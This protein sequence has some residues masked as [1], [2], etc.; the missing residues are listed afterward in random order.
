MG[1]LT[2]SATGAPLTGGVSSDIWRVDLPSGPVC[3]KR[4]LAKTAGRGGLAGAGRAQSLRGALDALGR[5]RGARRRAGAARPGRG[6]RR[7]G[8]GV[9]R[10]GASSAVEG[11]AARRPCR[12]GFRGGGRDGAG[13]HPRRHR[14]RSGGR[15]A[16]PD[17]RHLPRNPTGAL[18][19]GHRPRPPR[20]RGGAARSR[21]DH[22]AHQARAGAWRREPEEHPRRPARPGV[23]RRRVRLVGRSGLRPRLL[24][25]SFASQMPL[26]AARL[27]AFSRL[28]RPARAHLPGRRGLGAARGAAKRAPPISFPACFWPG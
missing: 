23:P 5:P 8:D 16:V 3:V 2:G 1:L 21:G 6:E 22:G 13:P 11:P 26:D 28:L 7:A 18:P 15:G 19:A 17:R 14:R 10:P 25:Q 4:A 24:P 27:G 12:P 20:P 9:S